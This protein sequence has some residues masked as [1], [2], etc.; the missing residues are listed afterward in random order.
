MEHFSSKCNWPDWISILFGVFRFGYIKEHYLIA[1]CVIGNL[2]RDFLIY[3]RREETMYFNI[4][5]L[6]KAPKVLF[7]EW[8]VAYFLSRNPFLHSPDSL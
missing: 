6:T 4:C 3:E 2:F 8:L 5:G 7:P 1:E